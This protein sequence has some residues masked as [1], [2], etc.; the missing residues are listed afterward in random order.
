ME[1]MHAARDGNL[2]RVRELVGRGADVNDAAAGTT[3]LIAALAAGKLDV[4]KAL[5]ALGAD[6][7]EQI[8]NGGRP[9]HLAAFTGRLEMVKVLVKAG[10]ELE[11]PTT[12]AQAATPHT[13]SLQGGHV[14]VAQ[15]L[16]A[17]VRSRSTGGEP[18]DTE[19]TCAACGSSSPADAQFKKC[20]RCRAVR[21][22]SKDCQRTHWPVHKATCTAPTD[23]LQ[24]LLDAGYQ[25]K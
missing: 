16:E 7:E 5:L 10:C 1:L 4:V 25:Y 24:L 23:V 21:Y 14:H 17:A 11:P 2:A 18:V 8:P 13:L 6:K 19:G 12:D 9:L 3:P 20:S 15:F 22:C